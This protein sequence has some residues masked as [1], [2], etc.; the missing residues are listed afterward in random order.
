M[1]KHNKKRN[2]G[3]IYELLLRHISKCLIEDNKKEVKKATRIIES[4]FNKNTELYK[5]FR[6]FNGLAK[7]SA[8]TTEVAAGILLEAKQ[9]ARR[10]QN[11]KLEKEKSNLIREIN[12]T[13]NDSGFYHSRIPNYKDY[14]S[15]QTL[16]NEWGK[17]DKS[18]LKKT[19]LFEKKIMDILINNTEDISID[20]I[21]ESN[22]NNNN[23]LV[24]NLMT[25]KINKKYKTMSADQKTIIKNYVFYKEQNQEKLIS[26]LREKKENAISNL[27]NFE[28][29]N[30]NKF[31]DKKIESVK[32]KVYKLNENNINDET[33]VKFLTI[34]NLI[35]ELNTS[36]E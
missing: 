27:E 31:L 28:K 17:L 14:A 22:D 18:D 29:I 7:S 26:F 15:I 21:T 11:K 23:Q 9:A 25:E 13:I 4:Y 35:D 1:T 2:V 16:I 30:E 34:S 6:L 12:Y 36:G 19:I 5:E 3:I 8:S 32:E 33:I 24:Y 20:T 10:I